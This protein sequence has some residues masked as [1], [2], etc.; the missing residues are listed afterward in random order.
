MEPYF[1]CFR[2]SQVNRYKT[3]VFRRR[4][5]STPVEIMDTWFSWKKAVV[6]KLIERLH[7]ITPSHLIIRLHSKHI[8]FIILR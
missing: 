2:C 4:R 1:D 6:S 7:K 3:V 8:A 5:C